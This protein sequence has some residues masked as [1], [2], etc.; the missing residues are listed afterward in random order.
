MRLHTKSFPQNFIFDLEFY[1]TEKSWWDSVDSI[2]PSSLGSY[3][4]KYPEQIEHY[5]PKWVN[6]NNIWLQRAAILFQLKY[7][8]K[9]D[10]IMLFSIVEQLKGGK[11]FFVNKA[12]GW[13]LRE[14]SKT[15]PLLISD[16]VLNQKL[17]NLSQ[18][19]ALKIINKNKQI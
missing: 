3:F 14:Y 1:I 16:F 12:I 19:E 8:N 7:K 6:S 18:R 13:A 9:T 17:S 10:V 4:I 2:V 5:I 11:E 15:N